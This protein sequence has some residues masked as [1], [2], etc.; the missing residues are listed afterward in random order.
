MRKAVTAI[1]E[2]AMAKPYL[3]VKTDG[4]PSSPGTASFMPFPSGGLLFLLL[5]LT[6]Y[7]KT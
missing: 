1:R 5:V 2:K 4:R 7:K 3:P 6:I